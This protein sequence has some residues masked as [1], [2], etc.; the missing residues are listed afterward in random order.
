MACLEL[1]SDAF[2]T[3]A[4]LRGAIYHANLILQFGRS[5]AASGTIRRNAPPEPDVEE[6][7]TM[8][9]PYI[10]TEDKVPPIA[11][12][13]VAA[14]D[15][16]LQDFHDYAGQARPL[17]RELLLVSQQLSIEKIAADFS[18]A[19]KKQIL[20]Q[21]IRDSKQEGNNFVPAPAEYVAAFPAS[22]AILA[23]KPVSFLVSLVATTPA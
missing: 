23:Q 21:I 14:A 6:R 10:A 11:G 7:F 8:R 15:A 19:L 5:A 12:L 18:S 2:P 9:P 1:S 3:R 13:D 20:C 16:V 4:H 22:E 17:S